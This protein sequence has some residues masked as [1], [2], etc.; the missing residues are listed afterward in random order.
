[1]AYFRD[2]NFA[3]EP[4]QDVCFHLPQLCA[5]LRSKSILISANDF[6]PGHSSSSLH[7]G[8]QSI[9]RRTEQASTASKSTDANVLALVP[10]GVDE[11]EIAV[12]FTSYK[13]LAVQRRFA[14]RTSWQSRACQASQPGGTTV[15]ASSVRPNCDTLTSTRH[16][17]RATSMV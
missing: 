9:L 1:M 15:A 17:Q 16:S 12:Y 3:T 10:Q 13:G 4:F 8:T 11:Q 5:A 14:S 7:V 2:P 6:L